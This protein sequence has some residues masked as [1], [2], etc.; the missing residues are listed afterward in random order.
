MRV[1]KNVNVARVGEVEGQ[2]EISIRGG[3]LE[4][5][6]VRQAQYTVG[7][8]PVIVQDDGLNLKMKINP[9]NGTFSGSF[10]YPATGT[11]I[12]TITPFSGVF[13][14]LANDG[15][16]VF[17]GPEHSGRVVVTLRNLGL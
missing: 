1:R 2:L 4:Q 15:R 17:K 5:P 14:L 13:Q 10:L 9:R 7:R 11:R 6:F 3:D 12:E 16:A 8:N